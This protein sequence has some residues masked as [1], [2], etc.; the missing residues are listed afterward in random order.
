M[1]SQFVFNPQDKSFWS[2]YLKPLSERFLLPSK[3]DMKDLLKQF[4]D[5]TEYFAL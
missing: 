1:E 3:D 4:M 2:P 5:E